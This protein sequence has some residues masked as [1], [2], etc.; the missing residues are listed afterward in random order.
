M[1]KPLNILQVASHSCI[2]RGGA[3]Q[4][5]RL[6]RELVERGHRVTCVFHADGGFPNPSDME[7]LEKVRA[8]GALLLFFDMKRWRS[9]PA[10]RRLLLLEQYDVLHSHRDDALKFSTL[11]TLMGGRPAVLVTNRGTTYRIK[12]WKLSRWA[13]RRPSL[14]RVICVADAV[15]DVVIESG[16]LAAEKVV[17]IYGSVGEEFHPPSEQERAQARA[18]LGIDADDFVV[19]TVAS[20]A[21]K[22]GYA[23]FI[24]AARGVIKQ[25][26]VSQ[27]DTGQRTVRFLAVGGKVARKMQQEIQQADLGDRLLCPG[28]LEDVPAALHAMDLFICASTKG[29]GLTGS[30]REA[31]ACGLCVISTRVSGNAEIVQSGK[32]G[33]L[34]SAGSV[35]ELTDAI[36]TRISD[37]KQTKRMGRMGQERITSDFTDKI[38][39]DRIE[40][41]YRQIQQE[42]S[43]KDSA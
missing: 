8:C 9:L 1:Q 11:A 25:M 39:G 15:R 40:R 22:K 14:D 37:P 38:R 12:P 19:G 3:V 17:T 4:V 35:E 41:L 30:I 20:W 2:R 5:Y 16:G 6:T 31:M 33:E 36:C 32:T 34:V 27:S 13:F 7:T 26:S 18:S 28:H 42:N 23:V 29:E 10:F 21:P 43:G 24:E